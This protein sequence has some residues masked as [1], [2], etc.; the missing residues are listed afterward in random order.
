M[1][2]ELLQV[3]KPGRYIGNEIHMV[4]KDPAKVKTRFAFCF[5]DV[6]EVG[7]SHL[8][9]Q[10]LYFFLNRRSDVYCERAFMPWTDMADLMRKNNRPLWALE[11]GDAIKDF[12]FVGF[13]LQHEMSFTNVLAMLDLAGVPLRSADRDDRMPIVCAGGPCAY[14]PEPMADFIDF[15]CI[16]DGE[17]VLDDIMDAYKNHENSKKEFLASIAHIPGIYVPGFYKAE[18]HQNGTLSKFI[19]IYAQDGQNIQPDTPSLDIPSKVK[20]AALL[21][22]DDVFFPDKLL[23][24]LIEV[25]HHRVAL[26]LYRG[27]KRG[28]RFCQAGIVQRPI[29]YRNPETLLAQAETLLDATGHEEVSLVSLSTS[30]YPYFMPLLEHLL[31]I[32]AKRQVNISLPSLRIDAI[33]LE[34][35]K[36]TQ[37]VRKSSLTFAPEAG[38]QRLRDVIN[39]DITETDV[40]EGCRAAFLA[41]FDRVKLYFMTGLPTES[42]LDVEAIADLAHVVVDEYYQLPRDKR[43]R[44][45]SVNISCSCF[46]PKPFTPF[47]WEAQDK[48]EEFIQKQRKIKGKIQKKQI[49]YRYH[50]AFTAVVEGVLSRGD[51]RV[52]S[53]IEAAY[54]LGA[55]FDS[56]TEMF[57]PDLWEKAFYDTGIDPDFYAHRERSETELLPWDFIDIGI[58]K[59]TLLSERKK[60]RLQINLGDKSE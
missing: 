28:C 58:P 7:M 12:S 40:A 32:T 15:F 38:T 50:D 2:D 13:T 47:Q 25:A 60:S 6:Y 18:Y 21:S 8:G 55:S 20:K 36:K 52:G 26:E 11:T 31:S 53:A 24:P 56:W 41:G 1:I 17:A 29:R 16:G 27:C 19:S 35:I 54:R 45:V 44:P 22:L 49:S 34:A 39:K 51:R 42:D 48:A 46:V 23:V 43:R 9:L 4:K 30:D 5:P 59:A 10:I 14:N 37:E 3:V 33:N 57:R